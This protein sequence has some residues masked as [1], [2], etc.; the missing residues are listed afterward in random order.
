MTAA[1]FRT[2]FY[3]CH[4]WLALLRDCRSHESIFIPRANLRHSGSRA[5]SEKLSALP[6]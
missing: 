4:P 6:L 5:L 3:Q 1:D 2:A